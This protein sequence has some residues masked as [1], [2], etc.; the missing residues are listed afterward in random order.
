[1]I[2]DIFHRYKGA[3]PK[4]LEKALTI[5]KDPLSIWTVKWLQTTKNKDKTELLNAAL[6]REYSANNSERFFTAGGLHHF[7]NFNSR[8]N[9]KVLPIRMALRH[10][11]NLPF[12]RLM[13]DIVHYFKYHTEGSAALT[14]TNM[15]DSKRTEY[16]K[17]FADKEGKVFLRRF[18]GK[19]KD[20][21][22]EQ[23]ISIL[24][25]TTKHI[26][27]RFAAI[28]WFLNPNADLNEFIGFMRRYVDH[29]AINEKQIEKFYNWYSNNTFTLGDKGYIA[30]MHPLELWLAA[31]LINNP[32]A[33]LTEIFENS[34]DQR[35]EVYDW[36]MKTSRKHAQDKR[37]QI[38]LEAEAFQ[39]IFQ[40]WKNVGYPLSSL[41]PSYATALGTS[42]DR[43]DALAELM[44]IV[45]NK[46]KRFPKASIEKLRFAKD[47]P[48]DTTFSFK[49]REPEQ[50]ISEEIAEVA[51]P[52]LLDVVANGT[53]IRLKD[54]IKVGNETFVLGGKTG[55]GDH[56]YQVFGKG[57][58]LIEK[59]VVNRT[60]TFMFIMGDRYYGVLTA[61]VPGRDAENFKFTSA[62]PVQI[63]K[64]ISPAL[65]GLDD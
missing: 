63:L 3:N 60:A 2:E 12:I 6:D 59:R 42:A 51:K 57:G 48:Y 19:Y 8:D 45:L 36:L 41:V 13:R 47:T 39:E 58:R 14:L 43:P 27:K 54:G 40:R 29:A 25:D 26:P 35:I 15:D 23:I 18:Y 9:N 50:V 61:F 30:R 37:I 22:P 31:Y 33:D 62:L 5:E 34:F 49:E 11:V 46:G 44:G 32:G 7:S 56:R 16:L 10:S 28:Y 1:V 20:K 65:A 52:L 53:A 55:T 38:L 4:S 24:L 21:T 64:I 17:K